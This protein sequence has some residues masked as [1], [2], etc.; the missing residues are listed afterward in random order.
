MALDV[1]VFPAFTDTPLSPH[2]AN[3][4]GLIPLSVDA[5]ACRFEKEIDYIFL[6]VSFGSKAPAH[7]WP[8]IPDLLS[9]HPK[10]LV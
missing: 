10:P 5:S 2:R 1:C 4:A 9:T 6:N 8:P 7:I 3:Y